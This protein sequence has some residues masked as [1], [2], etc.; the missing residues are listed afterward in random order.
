MGE[1]VAGMAHEL[2]QPLHAAK[3]FA[4][5]ARRHLES[6]RKGGWE[7][8]VEC[9]RE[10]SQAIG[11]T[12][13]IIRRLREF[14]KARPVQLESVSLNE[15]A[16]QA[17]EM[18]NYELRRVGAALHLDLAEGLPRIDGDRVQLEQ[19]VVNLLK[20]ACEALEATPPEQR[21]VEVR[22]SHADRRVR[23]QI[24][25]AGGGLAGAE[26][27]R[28]FDA[29]YSTKPDGMGMGLSLCK[30][31]AEAHQM[32]ISFAPNEDQPGMTFSIELR[33]PRTAGA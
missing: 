16:S 22:T 7:S 3:T 27:A 17:V 11:R 24:K 30:S 21:R 15:I 23:L 28:L 12:V 13:E 6:G 26:A 18:L 1:M 14:T 29:F 19:V 31:I 4:E 10:I 20:N 33:T 2:N 25:D 8:A 5:A 9:S 32:Q